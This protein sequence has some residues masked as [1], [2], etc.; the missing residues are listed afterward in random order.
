M[1]AVADLLGRASDLGA[2]V[3][4][5]G[6]PPR[7]LQ[8]AAQTARDGVPVIVNVKGVAPDSTPVLLT[9]AEYER[10]TRQAAATGGPGEQA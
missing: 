4:Y 2:E 10:L 8:L 3:I 9:L 1:A 5:Q 6:A 7:W